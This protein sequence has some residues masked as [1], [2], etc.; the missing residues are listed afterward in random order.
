MHHN[1]KCLY[2]VASSAE[3]WKHA[4]GVYIL[5]VCTNISDPLLQYFWIK[6]RGFLSPLT[7]VSFVLWIVTWGKR[8][9]DSVIY[10]LYTR[11]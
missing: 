6:W 5:Y 9:D 8:K 2:N 1:A 10:Q 3:K 11:Q 7:F 4:G